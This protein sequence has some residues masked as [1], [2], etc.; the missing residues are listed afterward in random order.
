MNVLE[1]K[2]RAAL[3]ETGEEIV[4]HNVPPLRLRGEGRRLLLRSP[5]GP[6]P[7]VGMAY[8]AGR[9]RVGGRRGRRLAGHRR[10]VPRPHA[11]VPGPPR[12]ARS[13]GAPAGGQ[14]ALRDVPPYFV[15]L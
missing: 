10:H 14:A 9:R 7:L 11:S 12:P 15:P 8:A 6:P 3:R 4:P 1:D 13:H 5:R 2:L